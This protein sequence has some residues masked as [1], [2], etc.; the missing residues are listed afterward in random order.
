VI[1]G[2]LVSSFDTANNIFSS[3]IIKVGGANTGI[4]SLRHTCDEQ[5][6]NQKAE[7]AAATAGEN[8]LQSKNAKPKETTT[9]TAAIMPVI[10]GSKVLLLFAFGV[11][12]VLVPVPCAWATAKR[13]ES[14]TTDVNIWRMLKDKSRRLNHDKAH[15]VGNQTEAFRFQQYLNTHMNNFLHFT[16]QHTDGARARTGACTLHSWRHAIGFL[17]KYE[18]AP[19]SNERDAVQKS[20]DK[21]SEKA[22]FFW[23]H[24]AEAIQYRTC[25][26]F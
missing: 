26:I 17:K 19:K 15:T 1:G 12:L 8:T 11:L 21:K 22:S 7:R 23:G 2:A 14:T 13:R 18:K 6:W 16:H 20:I 9:P 25:V 24:D 5:L 4:G 3:G 10:V